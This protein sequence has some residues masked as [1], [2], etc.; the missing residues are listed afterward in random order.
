MEAKCIVILVFFFTSVCSSLFFSVVKYVI[1]RCRLTSSIN[2]QMLNINFFNRCS[3]GSLT[4]NNHSFCSAIQVHILVYRQWTSIDELLICSDEISRVL[5]KKKH[6]TRTSGY[7]HLPY[8]FFP[9]VLIC[10][11]Y[12]LVTLNIKKGERFNYLQRAEI[13][14]DNTTIL[15]MV[16]GEWELRTLHHLTEWLFLLSY[17]VLL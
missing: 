3:S 8:L 5:K 12:G 9:F 10:L 1:I 17:V 7:L 15:C 6:I 14:R 11:C 16:N 13:D 4:S 2:N